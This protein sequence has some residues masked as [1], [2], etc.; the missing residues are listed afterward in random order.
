[1]RSRAQKFHTTRP[2]SDIAEELRYVSEH[3]VEVGDEWFMIEASWLRRWSRYVRKSGEPHP[4][5]ISNHLLVDHHHFPKPK[6]G[7]RVGVDYRGV[8]SEVWHRLWHSYGGGPVIKGKKGASKLNIAF[9]VV[10]QP[11][12]WYG[13][14]SGRSGRMSREWS[15]STT[16]TSIAEAISRK[17]TTTTATSATRTASTKSVPSTSEPPVATDA[18][19]GGKGK[20]STLSKLMRSMAMFGAG[21]KKNSQHRMTGRASKQGVAVHGKPSPTSAKEEPEEEAC[22]ECIQFSQDIEGFYGKY[23]SDDEDASPAHPSV[24]NC[25]SEHAAWDCDGEDDWNDTVYAETAR[26]AIVKRVH[27]SGSILI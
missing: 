3:D 15:R 1:M 21:S 12:P 23:E 27:R 6:E 20:E 11:P 5:P 26:Q 18:S 10:E 22:P 25:N 9:A 17:D 4:G 8:C 16:S 14:V 19:G 7:L 24:Y 13:A 2:A